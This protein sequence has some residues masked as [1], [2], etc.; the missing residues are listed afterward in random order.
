MFYV[1]LYLATYLL[2][3]QKKD[4]YLLPFS[5]KYAPMR[6]IQMAAVG[7]V[8]KSKRLPIATAMTKKPNKKAK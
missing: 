1:G 2:N 4:R 5:A 7:M 8:P 6:V 3:C